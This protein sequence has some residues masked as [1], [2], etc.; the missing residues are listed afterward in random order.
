MIVNC[1]W[2]L[3]NLKI[4]RKIVYLRKMIEEWCNK[5]HPMGVIHICGEK[6]TD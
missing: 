2:A 3:S 6:G 4:A 1:H 5:S